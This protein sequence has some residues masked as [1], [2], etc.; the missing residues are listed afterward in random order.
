[1][2]AVAIG[3]GVR[4]IDFKGRVLAELPNA[5]PTRVEA[6]A[7]GGP[8]GGLLAT[9]DAGGLI[10]VWSVDRAGRVSFQTSLTGHTG[11][12]FAVAFSPDG[13]TLASGGDD[14][15]V[16]LWDP[17]TGQERATLTGHTDR[18]MQMRFL[19]DASALVSVAR[20]GGVKRWRAEHAP[21]QPNAP[22]APWPPAIGG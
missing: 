22:S 15:T 1:M 14:R 12:V 19:P 17:I 11:P 13:R 5:H 6:V 2:L 16:L 21:A 7:F 10:H 4:L 8:D 18:V 20:D 3:N 9:A